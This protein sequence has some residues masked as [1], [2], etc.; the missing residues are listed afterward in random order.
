[1]NRS[2]QRDL[3]R[4]MGTTCMVAV[5]AEHCDAAP[6]RRALEVARREIA[7]CERALSRFDARSDLSLLNGASGSWVEIDIRLVE[8]L[9]AA[10]RAR[11]DT[12]GRFDPT[13]LPALVAAGYDSSFELL[14]E[15][16]PTALDAWNA[17]AQVDID[18]ASRAARVERGAAVDLGGI[19]KGFAATRALEAMQRTWPALPGALLDLGGDIA[20]SGHPPEGGPWRVDVE[21]PRAPD[22]IVGTLELRGGGVASSGRNRRRFGPGRRQH[23]LIDPTTGA[24][25]VLGPLAVTVVATSTTEAEVHA[26]ALAVTDV[27]DAH[28]YLGA[29]PDVAALLIPQYGESIQIG[30]PPLVRERPRTRLVVTMQRGRIS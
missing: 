23:H 6:A 3:F 25:A 24:P 9:A 1:M 10:L 26:T 30:G 11:I 14:A 4:A 16:P 20:V 15:R 21:D 27:D 5:T 7:A 13:I 8:A 17:G 29:R 12:D 22:K 2:L 19:G 18:H 28:D